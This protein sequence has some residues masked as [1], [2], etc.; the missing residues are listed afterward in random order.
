MAR[1]ITRRHGV[2]TKTQAAC[3]HVIAEHDVSECHEAAVSDAPVQFS[4]SQKKE[5]ALR[6]VHAKNQLIS[7]SQVHSF[8]FFRD[9]DYIF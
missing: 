7:W 4:K 1:M 6:K 3:K 9:F 8:Y 2:K 5:K